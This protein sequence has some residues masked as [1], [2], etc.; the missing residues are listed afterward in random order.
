MAKSD[1]FEGNP[2]LQDTLED[3]VKGMVGVC[4]Q[5]DRPDI[6]LYQN[7]EEFNAGKALRDKTRSARSTVFH[8]RLSHLSRSWGPGEEL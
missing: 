8:G 7:P 3:V 1:D 4:N 6:V 5:N 2:F